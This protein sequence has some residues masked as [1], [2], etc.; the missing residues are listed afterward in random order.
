MNK[1]EL[2]VLEYLRLGENRLALSVA[3]RA[4]RRN[5]LSLTDPTIRSV[6]KATLG[7][8]SNVVRKRRMCLADKMYERMDKS[9]TT[10]TGVRTSEKMLWAQMPTLEVDIDVETET[11]VVQ[12]ELSA[13]DQ[14][15]ILESRYADWIALANAGQLHIESRNYAPPR[16]HLPPRMVPAFVAPAAAQ[17]PAF[18]K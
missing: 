16:T 18:A 9:G 2:R 15:A 10:W 3:L 11:E 5:K 13:A 8:A 14:L 7:D 4:M 17:Q 1:A 6:L 12:D